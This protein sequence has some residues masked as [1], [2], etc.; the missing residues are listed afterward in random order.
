MDERCAAGKENRFNARGW[1][2]GFRKKGVEVAGDR[3]R[4]IGGVFFE[5]AAGETEIDRNARM[6]EFE[7]RRDLGGEFDL[8]GLDHLKEREAL[9]LPN[10]S[11]ETLKGGRVAREAGEAPK[12]VHFFG[13]SQENDL[14]PLADR[15]VKRVGDFELLA[16]TVV[17]GATAEER[18]NLVPHGGAV[19]FVA[20]DGQA[21]GGQNIG[22]AVGQALAFG[23]KLDDG[24]VG[25]AAAE[26]PDEHAF[27][28]RD[29]RFV[30]E[31]GGD[32]LV[33]EMDLLEPGKHSGA[34]QPGLG[35]LIFGGVGGEHGGAAHH[36]AFNILARDGV[37]S[38]F[39]IPQEERDEF[40]DLER[41]VVDYRLVEGAERE[42]G[43][44]RLKKAA[45]H[46]VFDVAQFGGVA[47]NG[48]GPSR[49][50][51]E[52]QQRGIYAGDTR[53]ADERARGGVPDGDRRIAG[54]EIDAV[55]ESVHERAEEGRGA[56]GE[57]A[58]KTRTKTR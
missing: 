54:A 12:Q 48:R 32:G 29:A 24:E 14:V 11:L 39:Q 53:V 8:G 20:G 52:I 40:F 50:G 28:L 33:L 56:G 34:V 49:G 31:G 51:G 43:L 13:V 23:I 57:A 47:N 25:G 30:G 27:G 21:A 15:A 38:G 22:H 5:F 36:H 55:N 7:R 10:E 42:D 45:T 16:P 58:G 4:E 19:V 41:L 2:L 17:G 44:D 26:V 35:E 46:L 6:A 3:I 37:G 1:D 9:V 18:G